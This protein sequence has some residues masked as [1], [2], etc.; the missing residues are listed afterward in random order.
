MK[1]TA[2]QIDKLVRGLHAYRVLKAANGRLLP[3][4]AVHRDLLMAEKTAHSFPEDGGLPEFK[5]EA[6]RRF[7]KGESTLQPDK[8]EDVWLFLIEAGVVGRNELEAD[9]GVNE[10]ALA[11]HAYL[12]S[13]SKR[14]AERLAR[15]V[16]GFRT[17]NAGT[18]ETERVELSFIPQPTDNLVGVEER[19]RAESA[20]PTRYER[21]DGG[22]TSASIR[23]G[24]AFT[25][26]PEGTLH[27]FLRG[28][29]RDDHVH[30]VSV[31]D[32][33]GV[34]SPHDLPYLLRSRS[35][36]R[37]P[38]MNSAAAKAVFAARGL[39][40][41][42]ITSTD[43]EVGH[44]LE[45]CNILR[46]M[47]IDQRR[48]AVTP[49]PTPPEMPSDESEGFDFVPGPERDSKV[50]GHQMLAHTR[51][52]ASDQVARAIQDGA[53]VNVQDANG[54]TAL[55]HAASQGAR[56]C[57]RLLVASGRCDCLIRDH[58]GRY[59]F[60]LAIEWARDYAVGRLLATKQVLQAAA[61][62]GAAFVPR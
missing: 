52:R 22:T 35:P 28:G 51:A 27:I 20:T 12:A 41:S 14:G 9:A 55:H 58:Q 57:I 32:P 4:K 40:L 53:D 2:W 43:E 19:V 37:L 42:P 10:E 18:Y 13:T 5:E 16:G 3:W 33:I 30:Y 36:E 62:G 6:L 7:A 8:L 38:A 24:F 17:L 46:F 39:R 34:T 26:S 45:A 1:F 25:S 54:M 21:K 60:E 23:R 49:P 47:P 31:P 48:R 15:L 29:S 59:A 61:R 50:L 11:V 56:P 44:V